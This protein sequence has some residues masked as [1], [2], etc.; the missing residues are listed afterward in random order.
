MDSS[1]VMPFVRSI[2][3]V[4]STM[5]H[6]QVTVLKP[7]LRETPETGH[8]VSGVIGFTGQV[9]GAVVLGFPRAS[10]EQLVSRFVGSPVDM[11]HPDFTDAVGEVV[12]MVAGAA[13]AK[14]T[15]RDVRMSCPSVVVGSGHQIFQ[16]REWPIIQL[17]C[18]CDAGQFSVQVTLRDTRGAQLGASEVEVAR[19]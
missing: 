2:Q 15:D 17:P 6:T 8:D 4:F 10:A 12:N 5:L 11:E 3:N 16:K 19:A 14:F 7:R 9:T 1:Y 18:E 13:K